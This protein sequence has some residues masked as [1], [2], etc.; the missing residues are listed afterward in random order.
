[1]SLTW[2]QRGRGLNG[3]T[4]G[5]NCRRRRVRSLATIAHRRRL[6]SVATW[7]FSFTPN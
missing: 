1:M 5:G 2:C 6:C 4:T 7:P 3:T